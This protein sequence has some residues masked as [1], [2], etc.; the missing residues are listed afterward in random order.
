LHQ[1]HTSMKI[2]VNKIHCLLNICY[3]KNRIYA[4]RL[5]EMRHTCRLQ[6]KLIVVL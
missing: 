6:T 2:F 1:N 3:Y 5:N 4:F